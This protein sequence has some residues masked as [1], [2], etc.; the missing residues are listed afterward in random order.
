MNQDETFGILADVLGVRTETLVEAIGENWYRSRETP[1]LLIRGSDPLLAGFFEDDDDGQDD[2]HE[3]TEVTYPDV[4]ISF[5]SFDEIKIGTLEMFY[6]PGPA[7][8]G[9]KP[10][11]T[12]APGGPL[13]LEKLQSAIDQ[14]AEAFIAEF[15]TCVYCKKKLP[16][17]E[18]SDEGYCYSCGEEELGLVY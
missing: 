16:T 6:S 4:G 9:L 18:M 3:E 17:Y 14:A 11:V 2:D 5:D 1:H 12:L 15:Q 7:G 13:V 8:Y 10:L